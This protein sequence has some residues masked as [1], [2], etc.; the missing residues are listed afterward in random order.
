MGE[1][2]DFWCSEGG[3]LAKIVMAAIRVF[4]ASDDG[5]CASLRTDMPV[6]GCGVIRLGGSR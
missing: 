6:R 4:V 2:A 3:M 1:L 5:S